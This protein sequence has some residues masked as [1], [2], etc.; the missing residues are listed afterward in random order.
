MQVT[1]LTAWF[2]LASLSRATERGMGLVGG[3][4]VVA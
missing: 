3:V 1:G 2:G 4:A